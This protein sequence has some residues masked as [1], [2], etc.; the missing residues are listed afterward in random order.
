MEKAEDLLFL[1]VCV[2]LD[3]LCRIICS[4]V[5]QLFCC[6]NALHSVTLVIEQI[7]RLCHA[8]AHCVHCSSVARATGVRGTDRVLA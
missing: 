1:C 5:S 4:Q 3:L 8:P 6:F 2:S 7:L